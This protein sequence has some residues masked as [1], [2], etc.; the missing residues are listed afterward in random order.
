MPR[1]ITANSKLGQRFSWQKKDARARASAPQDMCA[2]CIASDMFAG[3]DGAPFGCAGETMMHCNE[4]PSYDLT[5]RRCIA[6]AEVAEWQTQRTQNP[7]S[8]RV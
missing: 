5:S 3:C 4:E 8:E 2:F 6:N 1:Q 7:P